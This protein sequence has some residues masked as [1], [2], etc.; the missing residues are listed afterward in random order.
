MV[1]GAKPKGVGQAAANPY[2]HLLQQYMEALL[3][4]GSGEQL[5]LPATMSDGPVY[6]GGVW[7]CAAVQLG[8]LGHL[9]AGRMCWAL[10]CQ[11]ICAQGCTGCLPCGVL[12]GIK[13]NGQEA[14]NKTHQ[15]LANLSSKL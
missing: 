13:A 6:Q 12:Q 3:P 10:V 4:R 14:H 9:V 8:V 7:H 5:K 11:C 15:R 1:G 2:L